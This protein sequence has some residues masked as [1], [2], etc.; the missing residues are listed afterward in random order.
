MKQIVNIESKTSKKLAVNVELKPQCGECEIDF[1]SEYHLVSHMK[2][3]QHIIKT[4]LNR[5]FEY[6]LNEK[7][8]K[9]KLLKGA[10]KSPFSKEFKSTCAVLNF[11]DGSYFFSVLPAIEVWKE[12]KG[13]GNRQH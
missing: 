1:K 9:A 8:T 6:N 4:S 2:S 11:S 13:T 12:M 10:L 7:S 3:S 5:K